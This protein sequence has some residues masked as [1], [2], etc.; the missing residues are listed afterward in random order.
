MSQWDS[1]ASSQGHDYLLGSTRNLS[2]NK[3]VTPS[4]AAKR[5]DLSPTRWGRGESAAHIVELYQ[6]SEAT[7]LPHR[8]GERSPNVAMRRSEGE[9]VFRSVPNSL[10]LL[11]S[12]TALKY[13]NGQISEFCRTD[14]SFI[15]PVIF[16]WR[17]R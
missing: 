10:V 11:I 3:S 16:Q 9:G 8:V 12:V 4:P 2:R 17:S 7:P 15:L 1:L 13:C 14:S 6:C 5:R